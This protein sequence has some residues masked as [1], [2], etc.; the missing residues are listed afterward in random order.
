MLAEKKVM[1]PQGIMKVTSRLVKANNT[2]GKALVISFAGGQ[3]ATGDS[4]VDR[5]S[6]VGDIFQISTGTVKD[7]EHNSTRTLA[8]RL[9]LDYKD[10]GSVQER[11]PNSGRFFR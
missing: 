2:G 4:G 3:I 5:S 8:V 11:D 6:K 1:A 7:P 10:M 9:A